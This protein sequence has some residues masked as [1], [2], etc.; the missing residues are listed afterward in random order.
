MQ[1]DEQQLEAS[2]HAP[3]IQPGEKRQE[4][5]RFTPSG[6]VMIAK[7]PIIAP[8][9][10]ECKKAE[11]GIPQILE[12][13]KGPKSGKK[14]EPEPKKPAHQQ[15]AQRPEQQHKDTWAQRAAAPSP[16]KNQPEQRQQQQQQQSGQQPKMKGDGFVEVKRQQKEKEMKPV[17]PGQNTMEKRRVTFKRDNGL[18]LSQKMIWIFR[19]K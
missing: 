15:L 17:F 14:N 16:P 18:P 3:V 13:P 11:G 7:K 6:P 2:K 1:V 10:P 4:F 19:R 8:A 12:I 9:V 5:P